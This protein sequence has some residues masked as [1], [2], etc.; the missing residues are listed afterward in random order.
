[1]APAA[2]VQ[3]KL[4]TMGADKRGI[5]CYTSKIYMGI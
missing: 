1:M 4:N 5:M 2:G 3:K